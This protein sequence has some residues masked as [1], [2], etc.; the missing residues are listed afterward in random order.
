M[1]L[2]KAED[3]LK[4]HW[5]VTAEMIAI[6]NERNPEIQLVE[7]EGLKQG[8]ICAA[9]FAVGCY[10]VR[11][12]VRFYNVREPGHQPNLEVQIAETEL[13]TIKKKLQMQVP[14]SLDGGSMQ[15]TPVFSAGIKEGWGDGL[16]CVA[17]ISARHFESPDHEYR[18]LCR[19]AD[20]E[21]SSWSD[22]IKN[23][24]AAKESMY[25]PDQDASLF[26]CSEYVGSSFGCQ[27]WYKLDRK[28]RIETLELHDMDPD[29]DEKR[30]KESTES[31]GS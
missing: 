12:A 26:V 2:L 20:A 21:D 18:Y 9:I 3:F 22:V 30:F 13:E 7:N 1:D 25:V 29:K 15:N 11:G 14:C 8:E 31:F 6:L 23:I 24:I 28:G 17:E 4:T 5:S 16:R 10:M 19:V 27:T